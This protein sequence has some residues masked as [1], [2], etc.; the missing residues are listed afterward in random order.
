MEISMEYWWNDTER[1]NPRYS[2]K[3]LS[4]CHFGHHKYDMDWHRIEPGLLRCNA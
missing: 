2:D 3:T 4:Q 1:E